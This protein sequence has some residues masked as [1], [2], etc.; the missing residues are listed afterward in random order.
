MRYDPSLTKAGARG[1]LLVWIGVIAF[2]VVPWGR[3]QP[4]PNLEQIQWIPFVSPPIRLRDIVR[5]TLLYLPVGY[6]YVKQSGRPSL[7]RTGA[8]ALA[9]SVGTEITQLFSR[10]RFPSMTDVTCNTLGALAGAR[11]ALRKA[12]NWQGKATGSR[13]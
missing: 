5:N 9:L 12:S 2:L 13:R 3:L 6:W 10:S 11:W 8:C 1:L 7:W 4:Y